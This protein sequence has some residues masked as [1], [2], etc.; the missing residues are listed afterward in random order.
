MTKAG[1]MKAFELSSQGSRKEKEEVFQFR[2]DRGIFA[3]ADGFGGGG[4]GVNAA[5]LACDK[6]LQFLDREAG[7]RDATLPFVLKPY[8]SLAGNIVFNSVLHANREVLRANREVSGNAKGGASVLTGF[9]DGGFLALANV[10][11]C[12]ASLIREDRVSSIVRARSYRSLID[13]TGTLAS[14]HQLQVPL[15]ALGM[16]EGL[17]PE[18]AEVR[19]APGDVLWLQSEGVEPKYLNDFMGFYLNN[20]DAA[21]TVAQLKERLGEGLSGINYMISLVFI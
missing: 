21:A 12:S 3:M 1:Q 4:A 14:A 20:R 10:G 19:T 7:D 2:A 5:R 17:E 13:P 6:S 15:M 11:S 9:L 8:Y 18:I 16:V